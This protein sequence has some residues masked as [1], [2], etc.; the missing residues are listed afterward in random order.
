[1]IYSPLQEFNTFE[2][3]QEYGINADV[4]NISA[5]MC[6]KRSAS[7]YQ[8]WEIAN[9]GDKIE[10]VA[11]DMIIPIDYANGEN[12][13]GRILLANKSLFPIGMFGL[14]TINVGSMYKASNN[15]RLVSTS[16]KDEASF[17]AID[18]KYLKGF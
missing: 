14:S 4:N 2:D 1:M 3:C 15:G 7:G 8:M 16:N 6:L 5:G 10:G 17:I 18:S 13:Y 12:M 9:D 11:G